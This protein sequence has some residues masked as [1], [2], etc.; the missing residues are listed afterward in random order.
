MIRETLTNRHLRKTKK[1]KAPPN[2]YRGFE[3]HPFRQSA[4]GGLK[5]AGG[6]KNAVRAGDR[7]PKAANP[8]PSANP[9]RWPRRDITLHKLAP[10]LFRGYERLVDARVF[11]RGGRTTRSSGLR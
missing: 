7:S 9:P 3:S 4:A 1:S 11:R 10:L 5:H 8:T 2:T 6:M